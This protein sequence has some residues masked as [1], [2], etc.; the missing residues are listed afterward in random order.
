MKLAKLALPLVALFG[1]TG[2]FSGTQVINTNFS[3][4]T[5]SKQM[6]NKHFKFTCTQC[7]GQSLWMFTIKDSGWDKIEVKI[8]ITNETITEE[9]FGFA[10]LNA[11]NETLYAKQLTESTFEESIAH[12][13]AGKY[14]VAIQCKKFSGSY[15]FTWAS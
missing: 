14:R 6:D 13:G 11:N 10:L 9:T 2:C 4:L 12:N 8:N 5:G 3:C 15:T 7:T 1:V